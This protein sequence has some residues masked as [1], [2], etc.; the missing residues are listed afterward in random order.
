MYLFS[1]ITSSSSSSFST[2]KF[3]LCSERDLHLFSSWTYTSIW[4]LCSSRIFFFG[5]GGYLDLGRYFNG[6]FFCI[7]TPLSNYCKSASISSA[8]APFCSSC[9]FCFGCNFW[10]PYIFW[11]YLNYFF[12]YLRLYGG[13]W[14][15][16]LGL[17]LCRQFIEEFWLLPWLSDPSFSFGWC[18]AGRILI[19]RLMR[20]PR[21]KRRDLV[22][23]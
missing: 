7:Y 21:R 17:C 19:G 10:G 2:S 11:S 15:S 16:C 13:H 1:S 23:E 12:W 3:W 6:F 5:A 22:H 8:W 14:N 4:S 18:V 20:G 9:D